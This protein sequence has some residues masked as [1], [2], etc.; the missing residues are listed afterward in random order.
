MWEA[1]ELARAMALRPDC[2]GVRKE[3][4][5]LKS[6]HD[7]AR[8]ALLLSLAGAPAAACEWLHLHAGH[9]DVLPPC[10]AGNRV[11]SF[12]YMFVDVWRHW[13][14]A[15]AFVASMQDD[16]LAALLLLLRWL[17]AAGD[18]ARCEDED[19][20]EVTPEVARLRT[21]FRLHL[22]QTR[23]AAFRRG[24]AQGDAFDA[25]MAEL[26]DPTAADRPFVPAPELRAR[27]LTP[28]AGAGAGSLAAL[29]AELLHEARSERRDACVATVPLQLPSIAG[30]VTSKE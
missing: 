3:M 5:Q 30:V 4:C 26:A 22:A 17:P 13:A 7:A 23:A 24:S 11:G 19:D 25:W 15:V 21:L 10:R 28:A 2:L 9:E 1:S 29:E 27:F 8:R 14:A 18:A 20:A 16:A 6:G 12:V